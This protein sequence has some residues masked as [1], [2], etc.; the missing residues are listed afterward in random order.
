MSHELPEIFELFVRGADTPEAFEYQL[1]TLCKAAPERSWEVLALLDQ[2]HRRGKI[3]AELCRTLR[4][5]IQRQALGIEQ[6]E[7]TPLACV[8][9]PSAELALP[10]AQKT[11]GAQP[12]QRAPRRT[13]LRLS[14]AFA[15]CAL[16]LGVAASPAVRDLPAE[17]SDAAQEIPAE[18]PSDTP[19]TDPVML[20]LASDRYVV[21]PHSRSV[22][23]S[24]QRTPESAGDAS[25][26]WWTKGSGAKPGEDYIGGPPKLAQ[27]HDGVNSVVLSVPILRNP[28]R[29]HIQMF[30]VLIGKSSNGADVGPVRRAAVF[31]MPGNL[32]DNQVAPRAP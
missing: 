9:E 20:S 25:F 13:H 21:Y 32:A 29:R 17:A 8:S 22:E 24:V 28:S 10:P 11:T 2:Q 23:F 27:I 12:D 3:A 18:Q 26:L 19:S 7:I 16:L 30:Y 6:F 5:K 4:H 1:L 14:H 15:L 31:I